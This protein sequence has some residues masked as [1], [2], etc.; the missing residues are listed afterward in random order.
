MDSYITYLILFSIIVLLG[1]LFQKSIFPI[2]LILVIAGML[3]SFIPIFPTI[4]LNPTLVLNLFL[5][6]LVYEI[7]AYSSWRDMKKQARPIALLSIGHVIF[8]T[9][10]VAITIHALIPQMGWPLSFVLG[11]IISP[12]DNV[13]IVSIAEKIRIPERIFIILEGEGMF[14]DAAA[15]TLFRFTLAAAVS[16]Q[17]SISSAVGDFV[18]MLVGEA[19]YG[20]ILGH[21]IGQL[22]MRMTN[23]T[24]HV[25]ASFLT[26]FLAYVPMIKL[27]SSGIVATAM[28]GFIIGNQYAMRF[29]PTYRL[30]ALTTWPMVAYAIQALIFLLVGLDLRSAFLQVSAVPVKWLIEYVVAIAAVV[31]VGRFIWVYGVVIMLP[32]LLSPS[33]RK[34][35]AAPPWQYPFIVSWSGMRG[36]VS[37][38]AALA[39]PAFTLQVDHVNYRDLLVFLVF[40]I[41][42]ITLVLQ[43]LSLPYV[44]R[45]IGIDRVSQSERYKEHLSELQTRV[46]MINAALKWLKEQKSQVE[47]DE[48]LLNQLSLYAHE[49]RRLK[50]QFKSRILDHDH[51]PI[52]DEEAEKNADLSL[53]YQLVEVEKSVLLKLWRENK[54]NIRTRNKL[55]A[56]LD[57]QLHRLI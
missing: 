14:N 29:T 30:T 6:L 26:P 57:H 31:I 13:A 43:G 17:F 15:L 35:S 9:C 12:P 19:A 18:A 48:K 55:V 33:L 22:R 46:R 7:S 39:I 53:L 37:L 23:T 42:F 32:R 54:I 16:N 56:I 40:C 51:Q 47:N 3:L 25:I 28:V 49:Y 11:A 24:L 34:T 52:H 10:L 8:I 41:I 38:A 4:Q 44:L 5:P 50:H 36:G 45:K 1:E 20:F 21:L 2:A 27:G